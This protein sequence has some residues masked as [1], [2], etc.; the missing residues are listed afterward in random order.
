MHEILFSYY[1]TLHESDHNLNR[2]N[3]VWNTY[4]IYEIIIWEAAEIKK[5]RKMENLFDLHFC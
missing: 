1:K 2:K 4:M 3:A 5:T